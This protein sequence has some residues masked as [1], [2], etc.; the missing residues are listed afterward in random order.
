MFLGLLDRPSSLWCTQLITGASRICQFT[1]FTPL[2]P[3]DVLGG[4]HSYSLPLITGA[5]V[6]RG[7]GWGLLFMQKR[8]APTDHELANPTASMAASRA[9]ATC[10]QCVPP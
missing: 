1:F 10:V 8:D 7:L 9:I 4:N 6:R 3:P 2:N 5:L